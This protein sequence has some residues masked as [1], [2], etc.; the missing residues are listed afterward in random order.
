MFAES[1]KKRDRPNCVRC[2]FR[3][4]DTFEGQY[5]SDV[6]RLKLPVAKIW[7]WMLN[8]FKLL[9]PKYFPQY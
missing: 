9:K 1:H 3:L 7:R 8:I 2:G 5:N 4:I 6:F